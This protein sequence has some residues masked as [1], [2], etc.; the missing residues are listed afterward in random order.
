MSR[1]DSRHDG[2]RHR[3][4]FGE[5][6]IDCQLRFGQR[7]SLRISVHPDMQVVVD[8]PVGKPLE[9]VLAKVQRRAAWIVRQQE[10]FRQFMPRTPQRRY[11]SGE[12]FRYL[13]RQYR[14][15]VVKAPDRQ[16]KLVGRYICVQVPDTKDMGTIRDL[17]EGWYRE[18]ARDVFERRLAV[19]HGVARRQRIPLPTIRLRRMSR[20]WGSCGGKDTILLNTDLVQAPVHCIDYVIMHELCHFRVHCH[21]PAFTRL[22]GSLMPDWQRRKD[23]LEHVLMASA[24]E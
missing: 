1:N 24:L 3:I 12:T 20:R 19:C 15:K 16:V 5:Q 13:G 23:R 22:L 7:K 14:L 21:G 8:A 18:H 17:V 6:V 11:V 2:G 4:R 10:H 9:A